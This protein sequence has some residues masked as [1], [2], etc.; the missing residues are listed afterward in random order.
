MHVDYLSS[1]GFLSTGQHQ[2][3]GD[4]LSQEKPH[5]VY[6]SSSSLSSNLY[7][8]ALGGVFGIW[9]TSDFG[10]DGMDGFGSSSSSPS[11]PDDVTTG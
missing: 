6:S 10:A 4:F 2:R 8:L 7:G 1:N 9:E 3:Q 11:P 5:L